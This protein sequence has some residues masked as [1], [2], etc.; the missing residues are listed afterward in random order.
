M[1]YLAIYKKKP[2]TLVIRDNKQ[3][4]WKQEND[5]K[6]AVEINLDQVDTLQA[7]PP[8]QAK[9]LLRINLY[10]KEGGEASSFQFG[11]PSREVL[12]NVKSAVQEV[13]QKLRATTSRESSQVPT[14]G[15][16]T[17]FGDTV[18]MDAKKL[19]KNTQL[20]EA[21]L[22]E[23]KQLFRTFQELV[24][25]G[26]MSNIEFWTTRVHL[27]RNHALSS[28]QKKGAYNVLGT[29]KPTTGVD[30]KLNLSLTRE[31]IHDIF[32][33]YPVVQ[34]A[35]NESVP[36][37]SESEFW[38]RF[39]QSRLFRKLRGE[40]ITA[41]DP[42]DSV[43]DRYL[44][45]LDDMGT[46]HK[47]SEEVD[48][49]IYVPQ[50]LD[51]E[52]NEENVSEKFGNRPDL[53]MRP[54][55]S[56]TTSLLQAM[57]SLSQRMVY[58]TEDEKIIAQR[59]P[60]E[61]TQLAEELRFNDLGEMTPTQHFTELHM[62]NNKTNSD[63]DG[64]LDMT[65]FESHEFNNLKTIFN[66]PINFAEVGEDKEAIKQADEHVSSIIRRDA[67]RENGALKWDSV[68]EKKLIDQVQ[69]SHATSIEFLRHFWVHFLS[70][71][72]AQAAG[73]SRLVA[74]LNKSFER[75]DA[76]IAQSPQESQSKVKDS[77]KPLLN[78]IRCALDHYDAAVKLE[79]TSSTNGTNL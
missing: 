28:S 51:I 52:G 46:K 78:S 41:N 69:I 14:N 34:K 21:V 1:S 26:E 44:S 20:Q 29:I 56:D 45:I 79:T 10:A 40:R 47:L 42:M 38:Q 8:T 63:K 57:N 53:T 35:Y 72:P 7:T 73:L 75:I 33:Q 59:E 37:L 31:K 58:G 39:F 11:F 61:S 19:I 43:L 32:E 27:L 15:N 9:Q 71:D 30:N 4:A 76:V 6:F 16:P 66:E 54:G 3:I 18:D 17:K 60:D 5:V 12:D 22:K 50:Y 24:M 49:D 77:F 67:I 70:G 74:S 48:N 2:G 55:G 65:S 64:K 25:K 13:V 23:N 68:S 62:K 36:K